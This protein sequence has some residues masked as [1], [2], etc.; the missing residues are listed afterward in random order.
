MLTLGLTNPGRRS[1]FAA[2]VLLTAGALTLTGCEDALELAPEQQQIAVGATPRQACPAPPGPSGEGG[3]GESNI[4]VT[5]FGG[6]GSVEPD[7][8]VELSTTRGVLEATEL[9]TGPSGQA[10]TTLSAPRDERNEIVVTARTEGGRTDDVT[11]L[12]PPPPGVGLVAQT[13]EPL[14]GEA[15]LLTAL[16]I[17]APCNVSELRFTLTYDPTVVDLAEGADDGSPQIF[18]GGALNGTSDAIPTVL[19]VFEDEASGRLQVRYRRDDVPRTGISSPGVT[20]F[21]QL[22]FDVLEA[23]K[24]AEFAL[25]RV[26]VIPLDGRPYE[27][28]PDQIQVPEVEGIEPDPEES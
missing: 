14:V 21:L 13:S 28:P 17:G 16:Q 12:I 4:V 24:P 15:T 11:L 8:P 23:G 2:A 26:S 10:T 3:V 22:A 20:N 7:L 18:E 5:I 6:D 9:T 25:E 19:D 27:I 1:L